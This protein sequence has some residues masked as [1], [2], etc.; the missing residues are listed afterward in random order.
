MKLFFLKQRACFKMKG[1]IKKVE[2]VL[3]FHYCGGPLNVHLSKNTLMQYK[4]FIVSLFIP[5]NMYFINYFTFFW[6]Y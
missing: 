2:T 6:N 1:K 3:L 5:Y 4:S